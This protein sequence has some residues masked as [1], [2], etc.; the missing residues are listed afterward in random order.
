MAIKY[1]DEFEFPA[2]AG[3]TKSTPVQNFAKGGKVKYN[4]SSPQ[5]RMKTKSTGNPSDTGIQPARKGRSQQDVEAGGN[6]PLKPRF[7]KGGRVKK[8]MHD[9]MYDEGAKMGFKKGGRYAEGGLVYKDGKKQSY[10]DPADRNRPSVNEPR[11]QGEAVRATGQHG[12]SKRLSGQ[13]KTNQRFRRV[14]GA[15]P[16]QGEGVAPV[17]RGGVNVGKGGTIGAHKG[18]R[19]SKNASPKAEKYASGGYVRKYRTSDPGGY[20]DAMSK[21]GRG[22]V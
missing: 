7:A 18:Y 9:K 21:K 16:R 15:S 13:T 6:P 12:G 8:S 22:V 10:R 2:D 11:S 3:F 4:P 5:F 1:V 17:G 20:K 14:T 19:Q